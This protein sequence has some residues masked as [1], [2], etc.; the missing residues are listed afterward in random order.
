MGLGPHGLGFTVEKRGEG[1]YFTHSGGNQG[2]TCELVG[3]FAKG[4]GVVVMTNSDSGNTGTLIR[5]IEARVATA[6][7]WDSL[8]KPI[9]R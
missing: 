7:G 8:D 2:F 6:Y 3:H 9:P 4:Y 5:E 1:W